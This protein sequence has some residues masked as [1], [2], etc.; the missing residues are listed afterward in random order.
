LIFSEACHLRKK[1]RENSNVQNFLPDLH[2]N[3]STSFKSL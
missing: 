1:R 2:N 3:L